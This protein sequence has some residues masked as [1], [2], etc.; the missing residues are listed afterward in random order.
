M[1]ATLARPR[2]RREAL[3]PRRLLVDGLDPAGRTGPGAFALVAL[4]LAGLWGVRAW[5]PSAGWSRG[6]E[7]LATL[8]LAL[9]LVPALGQAL[10]RLNDAGWRGWWAWL[11]LVP[12]ARGA[13]VLLLVLLPP[14]QRRLRGHAAWRVLGLGAAGLAG[15]VLALSLLWTTAPV[16]AGNMAPALL[17]GDLALVRR[18]PLAV[19]PGDVVAFRLPGEAGI[20]VGRVVAL[21]GDRVA[22]DGGAPVVNGTRAAQS[23]EG[24]WSRTFGPEGPAGVLPVC[25]NGTVGLGASC[26]TRVLRETLGEASHLVLDAGPRPLDAMP[27]AVVP[28]GALFVLGDHRDDGQDSRRPPNAQGAGMVPLQAVLG[29]VD[30]V[31]ASTAAASPWDPRGWRPGRVLEGV[32]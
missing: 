20:R 5:G 16:A 22:V 24:S 11:L 25:G 7:V 32:E 15:L 26:A 8:L 13:L 31:L 27:E 21:P 3:T 19:A 12:F 29:R 18:A 4:V 6:W 28:P 1:S 17:P 30:R 9:L 10:R 2:R 14:S 23:E